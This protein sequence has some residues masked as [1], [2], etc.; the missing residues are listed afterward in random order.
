VRIC[1]R[2][3]LSGTHVHLTRAGHPAFRLLRNDDVPVCRV[4]RTYVRLTLKCDPMIEIARLVPS[5]TRAECP[6]SVI[7]GVRVQAAYTVSGAIMVIR[8]RP[9][10]AMATQWTQN[11]WSER[12]CGFE[13]RPGHSRLRPDER[14]EDRDALA[15]RYRDLRRTVPTP[16]DSD[17][18][19]GFDEDPTDV[20]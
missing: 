17:L 7:R 16:I 3:V 15:P 9:G 1:P 2:M 14:I 4:R 8:E 12:T 10:G 18:A 5:L 6:R 19:A 20:P 11:P 13:S